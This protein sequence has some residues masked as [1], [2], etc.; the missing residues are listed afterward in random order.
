VAV[1]LLAELDAPR[2]AARLEVDGIPAGAD[3]VTIDRTSPSGHVAGVRGAIDAPVTGATFIVRDYELP[4]DL[5]LTYKAT[6]YDGTTVVGT[7][8]ATFTIDYPDLGDP[9]LVD[10][11]RPTNSLPVTVESLAEL[12]YESAVGVHRVLNRRGPVLTALPA[13]TPASE[14]VAVTATDD[15]RDRVRTILGSGYPFLLR[16]PPAQGVGNLYL[17]VTG[18]TEERPSRIAM[19]PD[20]RFRV[21]V[22]QV[23]R[24]SPSIYVPRPP[25]TYAVVK[26]TYATYAALKAAVGS[27]E[28]L[29]YT[30]PEGGEGSG[31]VP[32][33]PDD[34]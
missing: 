13:W 6:V 26:A 12:A 4:F 9:W 25:M 14:L 20:R 7:A 16:T 24:P 23:E 19:H 29:A 32:W 11:A 22:V 17:G 28:E 21:A 33:P 3:T 18:F 1:T 34:V 31:S 15:E 30:F 8:T 10:L 5:Q 2:L 27:Y